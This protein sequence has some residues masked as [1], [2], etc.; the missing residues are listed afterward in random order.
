MA[1][2]TFGTAFLSFF[3]SSFGG[4]VSEGSEKVEERATI[5]SQIVCSN[6]ASSQVSSNKQ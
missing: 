1:V 2:H 4:Y 6:M 5:S 3:L